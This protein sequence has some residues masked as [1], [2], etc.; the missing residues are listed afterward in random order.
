MAIRNEVCTRRTQNDATEINII[1]MINILSLIFV[2]GSPLI[3][4]LRVPV[5]SH[6]NFYDHFVNVNLIEEENNNNQKSLNRR[7]QPKKNNDT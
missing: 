6:M 1:T 5:L 2:F 3:R 4:P 7:T